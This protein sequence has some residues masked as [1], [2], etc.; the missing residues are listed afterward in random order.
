VANVQSIVITPKGKHEPQDAIRPISTSEIPVQFSNLMGMETEGTS[1]VAVFPLDVLSEE[2][3]VHI[4][5]DSGVH[6]GG[7]NK[8]C[9]DCYTRFNLQKVRHIEG[10]KTAQAGAPRPQESVTPQEMSPAP[11]P[12]REQTANSESNPAIPPGM[13]W[14]VDERV[15]AYF[16]VGCREV[17]AIPADARLYFRNEESAQAAG[18]RRSEKC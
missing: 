9:E 8:Y 15:K 1:L 11:Q 13:Y 17:S 18:Y 4:I 6:D 5:Y 2:N 14:V 3:E 12:P 7:K 10:M 16:P